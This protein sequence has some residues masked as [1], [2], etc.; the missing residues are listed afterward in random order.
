MRN[1][2]TTPSFWRKSGTTIQTV[3]SGFD[4]LLTGANRHI[5]FGTVAGDSGYGFRDHAGTMQFKNN[6]GAWTDFGSG[7]GG[8]VW[9]GI[10][11]TLSDQT[12]L[13]A[14]IDALY[15]NDFLHMGA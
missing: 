2:I 7:G 14:V 5:N 12:D 6:A 1:G 3:G 8:G 10:T 13:Q 4:V 11:G 15:T 9:G